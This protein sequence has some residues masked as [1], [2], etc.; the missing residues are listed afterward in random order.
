M[1]ITVLNLYVFVWS[2]SGWVWGR[3]KHW[4]TLQIRI[5]GSLSKHSYFHFHNA[6]GY[7]FVSSAEVVLKVV[8]GGANGGCAEG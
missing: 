6:Q 3:G 4:Q 8:C 2:V 1:Y 5:T 7:L